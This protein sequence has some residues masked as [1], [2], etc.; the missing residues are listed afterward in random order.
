MIKGGVIYMGI[1]A[2]LILGGIAGWIASKIMKSDG[3]VVGDIILG[4]VGAMIGG[5][6]MSTLGSTGVTGLNVYSLLVAV[7]GASILI[8]VGRMFNTGTKKV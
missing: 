3:S 8:F 7:L 2:W 1:I 5:F 4:I 6:I